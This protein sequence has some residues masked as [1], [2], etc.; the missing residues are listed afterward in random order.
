MWAG[1]RV[2]YDEFEGRVYDDQI[3]HEDDEKGGK[4]GNRFRA[5]F[6]L[7][8]SERLHASYYGYLHRLVPVYGKIYIGDTKMCFRGLLPGSRTKV[9]FAVIFYAVD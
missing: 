6:A 1:E 4:Y 2:H 8:A 3:D 9:S 7:P 5:H